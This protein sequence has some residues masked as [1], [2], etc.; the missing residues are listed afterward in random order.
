MTSVERDIKGVGEDNPAEKRASSQL[1]RCV[2]SMLQ[3]SSHLEQ[4]SQK[5][6]GVVETLS[7]SMNISLSMQRQ[8]LLHSTQDSI[9]YHRDEKDAVLSEDRHRPR[10]EE[11][12]KYS[13]MNVFDGSYRDDSQN[14]VLDH[15]SQSDIFEESSRVRIGS[16]VESRPVYNPTAVPRAEEVELSTIIKERMRSKLKMLLKPEFDKY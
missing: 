7:E 16:S 3:A 4:V 15:E 11:H 2:A 8:Q 6:Q 1:D 14:W 13:N 9:V 12:Q 5:L 10:D